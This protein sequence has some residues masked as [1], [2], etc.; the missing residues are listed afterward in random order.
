MRMMIG[1]V[2]RKMLLQAHN[3]DLDPGE[4]NAAISWAA[5]ETELPHDADDW[6]R[7]A[8]TLLRKDYQ[9]PLGHLRIA[10]R[11]CIIGPVLVILLVAIGRFRLG[12]F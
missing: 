8:V 5:G 6:L 9:T 2:L 12:L 10:R 1:V 7:E 4:A 11:W 3:K